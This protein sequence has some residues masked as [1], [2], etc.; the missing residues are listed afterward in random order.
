MS[1]AEI[2]VPCVPLRDSTR[3]LVAAEHLHSLPDGCLV[4]LVTRA[5]ICDMTLLRERVLNGELALA[6]DVFDQEPL[7][8]DDRLLGHANVVHTP[9]NAGRT[10]HANHSYAELLAEQ[11]LP[12]VQAR[13]GKLSS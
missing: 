11:F 8:L 5:E 9:H 2:F 10:V 6:A 7:P 3:G 4:I 13:A 1:D 12:V